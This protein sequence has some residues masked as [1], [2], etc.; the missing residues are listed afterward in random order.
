MRLS[1]SSTPGRAPAKV[2][3]DRPRPAVPLRTAAAA[4]N[5]RGARAWNG[6]AAAMLDLKCEIGEDADLSRLWR[7]LATTDFAG[8]A[9]RRGCD[10]ADFLFPG[11]VDFSAARFSTDAWFNA[12][13]FAGAVDFSRA[14]FD[15]DG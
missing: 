2:P 9:F 13:R 11:A 7:E 10:F 15:C 5:G 14:I 4:R 12:A 1:S 6:W 3:L 8:A